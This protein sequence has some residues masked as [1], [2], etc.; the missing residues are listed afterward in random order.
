M[1]KVV[2]HGDPGEWAKTNGTVMS[3]I[4]VFIC[5]VFLGAFSVSVFMGKYTV[6]ILAGLLASLVFLV[7]FWRNGIRRIESYFV[8]ARGEEKV[9]LELRRL[10]DDYHIFHDYVAGKYH[11]DHVVVGP[12]GIYAVETKNWH[13]QVTVEDGYIL[14]GEQRL[15][16]KNPLKQA[17]AQ[18]M[19]VSKVLK[20]KN[21]NSDVIP[22]L[23][24]ASNTFVEKYVNIDQVDVMNLS[25]LVEWI[26]KKEQIFTS[27]EV[28]RLV[29]LMNV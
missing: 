29:K 17:K 8:G 21:L 16:S 20:E 9:A 6:L 7:V 4:P 24:F 26:S 14:Y 19:A 12:S 2:E 11:V 22:V 27:L 15:P 25:E 10:P 23:C 28:E 18:R 13:T 1:A 3:L 5:F